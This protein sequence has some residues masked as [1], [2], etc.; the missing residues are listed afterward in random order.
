MNVSNLSLEESNISSS[1]LQLLSTSQKWTVYGI[2]SAFSI[3]NIVPTIGNLLIVFAIW[4]N[5]TLQKNIYFFILNLAI[6]DSI[7][8]VVVTLEVATIMW[9]I[10]TP[11][12]ESMFTLCL[13]SSL[14]TL[15]QALGNVF[16]MTIIVLAD[17]GGGVPGARHTLWDQILSFSH[18]FSLKSAR[19]GGPRPPNGCTPPLWEI[20]DPPLHCHRQMGVQ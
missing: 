15:L 1:G 16:N 12:N 18:T 11:N 3:E 2:Y 20:L 6:I 7:G 4:K 14:M 5:S 13:F 17:L 10:R 8:F 19:I 9:S